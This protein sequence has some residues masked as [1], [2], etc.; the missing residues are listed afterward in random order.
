MRCT[1]KAWLASTRREWL[2][3]RYVSCAWD[4]EELMGK[5]EEIVGQ[6]KLKLKMVFGILD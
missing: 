1:S 3:G 2:G 5:E 4:M 6:D